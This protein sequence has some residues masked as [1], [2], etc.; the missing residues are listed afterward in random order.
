LGESYRPFDGFETFSLDEVPTNS[1]VSVILAQYAEC[2]ETLR[3][4]NIKQSQLGVWHWKT[5]DEGA[6]IR[7]APPNRILKKKG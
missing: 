7:S 4:N 5:K 3:A 6:A 2:L 1:D